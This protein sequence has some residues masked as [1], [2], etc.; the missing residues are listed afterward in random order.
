[1]VKWSQGLRCIPKRSMDNEIPLPLRDILVTAKL[2]S[3]LGT[4]RTERPDGTGP[5][6]IY[7]KHEQKG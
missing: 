1:M 3:I 4:E 5:T 6:P 2:S 7:V